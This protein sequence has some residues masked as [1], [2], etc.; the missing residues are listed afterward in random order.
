MVASV[1]A[2]RC[3]KRQPKLIGGFPCWGRNSIDRRL[4]AAEA[5]AGFW[6]IR[7][8]S[9]CGNTDYRNNVIY[10]W[11]YNSCYGAEQQQQK[12][13]PRYAF[14]NINL[15]ANYYK[16]GPTT[17]G[18]VS[19][20]IASPSTRNWVADYGSWYIGEN[21]VAGNAQ[22]SANNWNGG[23]QNADGVSKPE[24]PWPAMPIN[25]QSAD[26]AYPLVLENVG[27]TLPKRDPVDTRIVEET[28]TVTATFE[29][30]TYEQQNRVDD[31]SKMCGLIDSQNDVGG[32][33]ELKSTPAPTDTDHD[34]MPDDWETLNGLDRRTDSTQ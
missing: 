30:A 27:A 25:Q 6:Q 22:V 2:C 24:Q 33:P 13:N 18:E 12:G 23:V 28:R 11:G 8:A 14:S 5:T 3:W 29:G 21:F 19:Y 17:P 32:W 31:P 10:N 4:R 16:P 26:E 1:T 20:R 7:F 34:G 15:V 9:G